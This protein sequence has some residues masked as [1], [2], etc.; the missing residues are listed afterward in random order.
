MRAPGQKLISRNG[1]FWRKA[2]LEAQRPRGM[3]QWEVARTQVPRA[4][5]KN[6]FYINDD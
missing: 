6:S 2:A 5:M 1:R 4:E 3:G